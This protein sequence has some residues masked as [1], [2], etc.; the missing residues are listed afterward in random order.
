MKV[1]LLQIPDGGK[2]YEG[3]DPSAILDL[4]EPDTQPVSPVRYALDV[5]L[6]DGGLFATGE[7]GVDMELRCVNCLE[8]F[9]YPVRVSDFAL[10]MELP[11]TETIDLTEPIREDILLALPAHPHCDWNGE[12]QCPGAF[13][14]PVLEVPA[15]PLAESRDVWGALDEIKFK[16]S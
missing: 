9:Q 11:G 4:H 6:S 8:K 12:K 15:E 16:S 1:H 13:P 3:E 7:V 2:H 5:G 10:Q 14:T